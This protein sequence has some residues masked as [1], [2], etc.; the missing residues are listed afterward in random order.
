MYVGPKYPH[1]LGI[2]YIPYIILLSYLLSFLAVNFI[3]RGL[4]VLFI[5]GFVLLNGQ[6]YY[7]LKNRGNFQIDRAKKI[8]KIIFDDIKVK[9]YQVTALP[10]Q[11]SDPHYRY[12]LEI[13]GKRPL[14][15]DSLERV[16]ILYVICEEACSPQGNPQWDIAY[17]AANKTDKV[18]SVADVKIYRLTH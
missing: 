3:G 16:D 13:W 10:H 2:L 6:N 14:E 18:W 8:S 1:Y 12:F 4:L 7:F 11:Y 9:K 15:K 5:L 17:F